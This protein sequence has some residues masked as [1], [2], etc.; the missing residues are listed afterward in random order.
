MHE[1]STLSNAQDAT[2]QPLLERLNAVR[3]I[4]V[5]FIGLGY[6]STMAV[7]PDSREWLNSFGYDPSIFGLQILFFL[8][9]WLAW[10][11]LN[12][13][14]TV[15]EFF[16]SRIRRNLPWIMIYTALVTV[17]LY[18]ILCDH[19]ASH[20]FAVLD[21]ALYF[22]RTVT[23]VDPGGPMPGALDNALYACLLQGAIWSL[24][25]GMIAYI[26]VVVI[27]ILGLKSSTWLISS[28]ILMIAAHVGVHAWMDQEGPDM[29]M[30]ILSGTRLA[31]PFLAGVCAFALREHLPTRF[32]GWAL[33]SGTFL[34]L[35][36][37]HFVALPWSYAIEIL[38]SA[39]YCSLAMALLHSR[40][41]MLK[42]WPN[43]TLPIFLGVWPIAQLLLYLQ[44]DIL[45]PSLVIQALSL[46][47]LTAS[48]FW[49]IH[50][51]GLRRSV[52]RRVQTA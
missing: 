40:L 8:S 35:A 4:I 22:F 11:S 13:G 51:I 39:G 21:L 46:A 2:A 37:V 23:L 47:F 27:H 44:P 9:G 5:T 45:V 17:I 15:F 38:A 29:L 3:L 50:H 14:R 52:H 28:L 20:R 43:L 31:F 41:Q 24:R 16:S 12:S 32:K 6:A 33:T 42:G 48:L 1:S 49:T 26:G 19:D 10:R 34:T 7:G 30:H 25:W 18:P 36:T